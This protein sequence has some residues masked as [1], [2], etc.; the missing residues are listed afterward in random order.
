[1]VWS[2]TPPKEAGAYDETEFEKRIPLPK[3]QNLKSVELGAMALGKHNDKL[4]V[5]IVCSGFL[6]GNG[7]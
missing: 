1:M 5:H 7:E 6:Y 3:Y 4:R 2:K